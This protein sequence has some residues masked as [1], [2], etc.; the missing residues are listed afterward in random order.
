MS[1][2]NDLFPLIDAHDKWEQDIVLSR[3]EPLKHPGSTDSSIYFILEGSVKIYVIES[4]HEQI[5]RFG[6]EGEFITALDSFLTDG[7]SDLGVEVLEKTRLKCMSKKVFMRIVHG[8]EI[9]RSM[10][11][12]VMKQMILQQME[13]ERDLLTESPLERY[14][15]V[16]KRSPHLFQKVSSKNIASYLRMSP[17]TLSRVKSLDLNQE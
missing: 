5:L 3:N 13:R 7:S 2:L 16:M 14:R 12:E 4:G 11:E 9:L 15:R 8:S 17:E 1:L 10:W 6:Y